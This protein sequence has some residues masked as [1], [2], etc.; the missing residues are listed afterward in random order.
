MKTLILILLVSVPHLTLAGL[1]DHYEARHCEIFVDKVQALRGSHGD[2]SLAFWIKVLPQRLD[3]PIESVGIKIMTKREQQGEVSYLWRDYPLHSAGENYWLNYHS[4]GGYLVSYESEYVFYVRTVHQTNYWLHP[5][6]NENQNFVGNREYHDFL[7]G[8][9]I[10]DFH[11]P[12][13]EKA[14]VVNNFSELK[15]FNPEG[16][17]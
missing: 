13:V 15:R 6:H 4:I 9:Q 12:N 2:R 16:C 11:S 14:I 5:N 8:N 1:G 7:S 3:G 17:Y 10:L